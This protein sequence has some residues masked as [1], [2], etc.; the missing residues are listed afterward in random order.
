MRFAVLGSGKGSNFGAICCAK[1]QGL[2]TGE[3]SLVIS[4]CQNAGILE[5]ADQHQIKNCWIDPGPYKTK[6]AEKNEMEYI[7]TI[8]KHDTD[9]IVLAGFMRVIKQSFID[10]FDGK[11]INIHPSLLPSFKGLEAWKQA[12]NFGVKYT[13]CTVHYVTEELDSGPII[14]QAIVE[15]TELD[16]VETL[17]Q[18]IQV[19]EHKLLP[20]VMQKIELGQI[21]NN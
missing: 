6:F 18:K 21:R 15:I 13:G 7:Q 16:T 3:I 19:E 10:A 9:W 1:S 14:D 4:D 11:V 8:K 20:H 17:H 2:F 5:I 12:F